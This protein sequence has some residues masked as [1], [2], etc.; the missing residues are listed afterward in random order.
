MQYTRDVDQPLM[1]AIGRE[2]LAALDQILE[3]HPWLLGSE[4]LSGTRREGPI[5]RAVRSGR[6][7][8]V[9]HLVAKGAWVGP[10][11]YA[12]DNPLVL[13]ARFYY[14]NIFDVLISAGASFDQFSAENFANVFGGWL[15]RGCAREGFQELLS[16]GFD[17]AK[18]DSTDDRGWIMAAVIEKAVIEES[19]RDWIASFERAGVRPAWMWSS[20]LSQ[21]VRKEY[22]DLVVEMLERGADPSSLADPGWPILH[23]IVK[24]CRPFS[25][26]VVKR[27][28][29]SSDIDVVN[30]D[31]ET[32]LH[33][34]ATRGAPD[35]VRMLISLGVDIHARAS[36]GQ[37]GHRVGWTPL[38]QAVVNR[39][40]EVARIL[41]EAGADINARD[42]RGR[43]A[44]DVL[45]LE[46][47]VGKKFLA[48][49][50]ALGAR[51]SLELKQGGDPSEG[52][53]ACLSEWLLS[54]DSW[55]EKLS[56]SILTMP[57]DVQAAWVSLLSHCRE[58]D[59]SKPGA[60]WGKI[61]HERLSVIG[62]EP[63]LRMLLEILPHMSEKTSG[64][65]Q[66]IGSRCG[67]RGWYD[68][69]VAYAITPQHLPLMRSLIWSAARYPSKEMAAIL[70]SLAAS[71]LAKFPNVGMRDATLGN[72]ALWSLSAMQG[73]FGVGALVVL[74][75]GTRYKPALV[76]ITRVLERVAR[77][78][79]T[80]LE[81]LLALY[82]P[83]FG[84][85][86]VG[87][88]RESLGDGVAVV[89]MSA[90]GK[91][92]LAWVA[93]DGTIRAAL[94]TAVQQ[95]HAEEVQSLKLLVKDLQAA[96]TAIVARLEQMYLAQSPAMPVKEWEQQF[97]QH[98]VVAH[99]ARRL[100]WRLERDD[101][102]FVDVLWSDEAYEDIAGNRHRLADFSMARLW[103]PL[104]AGDAGTILRWR[105]RLQA[106]GV[107]QPFRQVHREVYLL[108]DAER[109]TADHSLRFAGHLVQQSVL[110]ALAVQRGWRQQRGGYW[111]GG[112]ETSAWR[113]L[114][115]LDLA[116]EFET[117]PAEALGWASG[118]WSCLGT[119][120][121]RVFRG[122]DPAPLSG[123]PPMVF[124]EVMRDVDLFVAVASI[125]NDDAWRERAQAGDYWESYGF[126]EL[127]QSAKN[128]AEVLR[129]LLP[130]L[131]IADRLSIDGRFLCVQGQLGNYRIHLGSG[132][133]LMDPGNQYLCIVEK[134][135]R[136][137]GIYLPF[138]GD[139]RLSLIISKA[140]LLVADQ[141]ITDPA[142]LSQISS[143]EVRQ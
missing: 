123:L 49:M 108:T 39:G 6:L 77:E 131:K 14:W 60:K 17:L 133:V 111:D 26:P 62:D 107:T 35:A 55:A 124:S 140:L 59:G 64:N 15:G 45:K 69:H 81:E 95:E 22:E 10:N 126:G 96:S 24:Q 117:L 114:P 37:S 8:V 9:R 100:L 52:I 54:G 11:P 143:G 30:R 71:M 135:D 88:F 115:G 137:E 132:N 85:T 38:M 34:A 67:E 90:V 83:D 78:R 4:Y 47:N 25:L 16:R 127:G 63:V 27:L 116:V 42:V 128:R 2:D 3:Q 89:T 70:R 75:G 68:Q 92:A 121:V 84:L 57:L 103:H 41:V 43:T 1:E 97:L 58:S 66:D 73:D 33:V 118:V 56:E 19:A 101:G 5:L 120:A 139:A 48:S 113:S 106:L 44:L 76:N 138:E 87:E 21:A 142:I 28:V 72:A 130:A 98:R 129:Q 18:C 86:G 13:A 50:R 82:V 110:H 91:A 104:H 20:A 136:T 32:A 93:A 65:L 102:A 119:A 40:E 99:L 80:T 122:N 105:Q 141:K 109:A 51:E 125:G 53:R 36:D 74:H 31:G 46:K 134:R 7:D 94:P 23:R 12:L 61:L 112:H 29:R 79:K